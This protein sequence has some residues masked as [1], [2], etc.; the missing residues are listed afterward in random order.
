MMQAIKV[1]IVEDDPVMTET[2]SVCFYVGWPETSVTSVST[3]EEGLTH[4]GE[5]PPSIVILDIGLPG[6]DGYQVLGKI[7]A[8]SD[9]PVILLTAKEGELARIKGLELGA[10]DYVSKP[11]SH[12]VLIARVKAV[13][14][15]GPV[16][17][18]E[19]YKGTYQNVEAKL[20]V[21]LDS[22]TVIR[23]GRPVDLSPLE[24]NLFE[25]MVRNEGRVLSHEQ[26]LAQVWGR[27]YLDEPDYVKVFIRRIRN[28]LSD[29]P[30]DPELIHSMRGVGYVFKFQ[31][32][33]GGLRKEM[34][35]S[36]VLA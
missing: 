3:G 31:P 26:I 30:Q 6:M 15:R 1:L 14:R 12:I 21:N 18:L 17:L 2:L 32:N 36:G 4:I 29:D 28:K 23:D 8:L 10:D 16:D 24:Y 9:V 19:S 13:L 11:F 35:S 20:E 27:E 5:E 34:I 22:R 25:L 7:R 33:L